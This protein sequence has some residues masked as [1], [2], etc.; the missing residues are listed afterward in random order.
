ESLC[1]SL[2]ST[3]SNV[4]LVPIEVKDD[5]AAS[6]AVIESDI[7]FAAGAAGVQLISQTWHNSRV[8]I[9]VDLNAVPPVGI[10]GIEL[11]D[12][13]QE[14]NGKILYG[15]IGVGGLKMKIHR[16]SIASLFESNDQILDTKGVYDLGAKLLNE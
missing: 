12:D 4:T 6:Q 13:G 7:L 15:A 10:P 14:R 5:V 3:D 2:T 11:A 9:A 16:R 1:S 8:K